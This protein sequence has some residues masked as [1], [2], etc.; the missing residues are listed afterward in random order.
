VIALAE[1]AVRRLGVDSTGHKQRRIG[2]DE[3]R[4]DAA[5]VEQTRHDVVRR[6]LAIRRNGEMRRRGKSRTVVLVTRGEKVEIE[7]GVA[8]RRIEE[9]GIGAE[10]T[11]TAGDGKVVGIGARRHGNGSED[12][13]GYEE[14]HWEDLLGVQSSG[15]QSFACDGPRAVA[16]VPRFGTKPALIS[17]P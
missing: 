2:L 1:R 7:V 17:R 12:E 3:D 16:T 5:G 6:K 15:M 9:T 10:G 11:D 13:E 4:S 14:P 8:G